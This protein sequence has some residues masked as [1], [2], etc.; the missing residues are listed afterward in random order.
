MKNADKLLKFGTNI[1]KLNNDGYL[2]FLK[3][4]RVI[5]PAYLK[6]ILGYFENVD[7]LPIPGDPT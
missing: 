1:A 2:E 3:P 7:I 6:A 4:V 5:H